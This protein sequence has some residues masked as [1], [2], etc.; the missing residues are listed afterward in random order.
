[1]NTDRTGS[2]YRGSLVAAIKAKTTGGARPPRTR[3]ASPTFG[4]WA[5][6]ESSALSARDSSSGSFD[7]MLAHYEARTAHLAW[8]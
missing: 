6:F 3:R 7:E 1:V 8:T 4:Q 2:V 5:A